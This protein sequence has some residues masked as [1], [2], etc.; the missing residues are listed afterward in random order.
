MWLVRESMSAGEQ[1]RYSLAR[2]PMEFGLAAP[3][4]LPPE[5]PSADF[6]C[7]RDCVALAARDRCRRFSWRSTRRRG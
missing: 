5:R 4:R 1:V 6:A 2:E 7:H 3:Q